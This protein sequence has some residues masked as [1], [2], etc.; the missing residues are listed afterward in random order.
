MSKKFVNPADYITP[1]NINGLEG[2]ILRLKAANKHNKKEILVIYGEGSNLERWWGLDCA[3][4]QYANITAVDLPGL[5][6]MESF[7]K[8]GIKPSIDAFADYLET[9]IKLRYKKSRFSVFAMGFGF[10]VA[11][12]MLQKNPNIA[13]RV[14]L[15]V[16]VNGFAHHS[17][18]KLRKKSL[19]IIFAENLLVSL[20]LGGIVAKL[21][22][23]L[24]YLGSY[25]PI[26]R[27]VKN[28]DPFTK[29]F[30]ADLEKATDIRTQINIRRSLYRLDNCD[31][32][33]DLPLWNISL[34]DTKVLNPSV[35]EQ[36]LRVVYTRYRQLSS[37][38]AKVPFI[39][40]DEK[41]G[42]KL[43]P[44]ALRRELKKPMR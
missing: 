24:G 34:G 29:K 27:N 12:R 18:L 25:S 7:Y 44:A 41:T 32:R 9:Y 38:S 13:S 19:P 2:R 16:G 36:H 39:I 42:K 17:D 20:P 37:K 5:G 30:A 26:K 21:M 40:K 15:V 10:V 1:I 8:I 3:L 31:Q 6:G 22:V 4:R 43:I 35:A 33:V 23:S 11:T 14:H 28:V